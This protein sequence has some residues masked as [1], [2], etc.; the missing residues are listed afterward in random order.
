MD[1]WGWKKLKKVDVSSFD[2]SNVKS[3]DDLFKGCSE[4]EELDIPNFNMSKVRHL[5]I[6]FDRCP[7]LTNGGIKINKNVRKFEW[8]IPEWIPAIEV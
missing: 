4:L 3:I 2:T 5:D 7:N 1:D 6:I 8:K